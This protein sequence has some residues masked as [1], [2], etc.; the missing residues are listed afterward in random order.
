MT[1]TMGELF[2]AIQ[3]KVSPS[4]DDVVVE[5]VTELLRTGRVKYISH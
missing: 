4:E 5:V 2:T 1:M 3:N